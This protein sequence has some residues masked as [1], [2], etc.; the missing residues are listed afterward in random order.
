MD[1]TAESGKL[2][3]YLPFILPIVLM[4]LTLMVVALVHVLRHKQYRMG[5]RILWVILVV[6][7]QIIGPILYFTLGRGEEE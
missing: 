4:E 1:L 5:N 6:C 3:E 7:L 2:L